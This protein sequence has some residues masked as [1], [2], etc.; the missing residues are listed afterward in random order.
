MHMAES[1]KCQ[2]DSTCK[3]SGI[4]A[5]LGCHSQ[6]CASHLLE[7]RRTL[8]IHFQE[9][10]H[11]QN[12]LSEILNNATHESRSAHI[13][14]LIEQWEKE[15]IEQLRNAVQRARTS[16]DHLL[17]QDN[18]TLNHTSQQL[19]NDLQEKFATDNYHEADIEQFH[20]RLQNLRTR[21][22]NNE[23]ATI[24]TALIEWTKSITII[25]TVPTVQSL[26]NKATATAITEWRP[27]PY[28]EFDLEKVLKSEPR[29]NTGIYHYNNAVAVA[30]DKGEIL[31]YGW[32]GRRN[33]RLFLLDRL[34]TNPRDIHWTHGIEGNI[35][36]LAWCSSI[37]RFLFISKDGLNILDPVTLNIE[38]TNV[39]QIGTDYSLC[40]AFDGFLYLVS[41]KQH[42]EKW[43]TANW[44]MLKKWNN[45]VDQEFSIGNVTINESHVAFVA[46]PA[47][48]FLSERKQWPR[49][50]LRDHN[51]RLIR[52]LKS[53]ADRLY[54][55]SV[56]LP[57]GDWLIGDRAFR[58][59]GQDL[60]LYDR[61][62]KQKTSFKYNHEICQLLVLDNQTIAVQCAHE[63]LL[64]DY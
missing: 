20:Q 8:E 55:V 47:E 42:I 14:Q 33:Q 6:F 36:S 34:A 27:A 40:V 13:Y 58:G 22:E 62:G 48:D 43:N 11:E 44:G 12:S 53:Y 54:Y 41:A 35:I 7:H 23:P 24:D 59:V 64:I 3:K 38:L 17:A 1:M 50:E 39:I 51:M 21:I 60:K 18:L 4:T 5:C 26:E 10:F 56:L 15:Q 46:H 29:Y 45:V 25:P 52:T 19:A 32:N 37:Q 16:A 2:F 63:L 57:N 31:W 30:S 61:N 28:R 9:L 49:F